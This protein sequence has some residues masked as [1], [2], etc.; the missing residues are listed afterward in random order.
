MELKLKRNYLTSQEI[1]IVI[2]ESINRSTLFERRVLSMALVAQMLIEDLPKFEDVDQI[3]DYLMSNNIDLYAK[4]INM[5]EIDDC[6]EDELGTTKTIK[7]FL[8]D[9]ESKIDEFAKTVDTSQME[10]LVEQLKG[11]ENGKDIQD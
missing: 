7:R 1:L 3:Y 6:L 4:V 11:M 10:M 9:L 5:Y 2:A 8:Q